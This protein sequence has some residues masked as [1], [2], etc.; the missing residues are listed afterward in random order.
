M[1]VQIAWEIL[2]CSTYFFVRVDMMNLVFC[3]FERIGLPEGIRLLEP[4]F[5]V[6]HDYVGSE[7][8]GQD[9]KNVPKEPLI[10]L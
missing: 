4:E 7:I 10:K 5:P 6:H 8:D 1:I 2:L 3:V 9:K